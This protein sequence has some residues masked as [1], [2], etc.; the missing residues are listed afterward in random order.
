M[1]LQPFVEIGILSYFI[2][3]VVRRSNLGWIAQNSITGNSNSLED[4]SKGIVQCLTGTILI[5][6]IL[7]LILGDPFFLI[8]YQ[9]SCKTS[10]QGGKGKKL[11]PCKGIP[12]GQLAPDPA[13]E[14]ELE[15][16]LD[17]EP[18][19]TL[20]VNHCP[21]ASDLPSQTILPQKGGS[22]L[23]PGFSDLPQVPGSRCLKRGTDLLTRERE[24]TWSTFSSAMPS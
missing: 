7:C 16:A 8:Y 2:S 5:G 9:Q 24:W 12:H 4:R 3:H 13:F 15:L 18:A 23:H 1:F 17:R 6:S 14:V 20:Q 21:F 10:Y 11:P 19:S 22:L